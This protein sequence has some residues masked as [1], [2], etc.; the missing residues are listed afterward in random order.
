VLDPLISPAFYVGSEASDSG[1]PDAAFDPATGSYLV[2]WESYWSGSDVDVYGQ[3]ISASGA[4]LGLILPVEPGISPIS[5]NPTVASAPGGSRYLV[6][7][8]QGP[9]PLGP[10]EVWARTVEASSG[11]LGPSGRISEAGKHS[12][13]P[14]AGTLGPG[15]DSAALVWQEQ[16]DGIRWA[17]VTWPSGVPGA[18][19]QAQVR[20]CVDCARPKI[21]RNGAGLRALVVWEELVGTQSDVWAR[22][23]TPSGSMTNL[24]A[25]AATTLDESHPDVDGDG[26]NWLVAYESDPSGSAQTDIHSRK[27]SYT[28]SPTLV[29]GIPKTVEASAGQ[30]EAA[31]A[32]AYAGPK[33]LVAFE[34]VNGLLDRDVVGVGINPKL[35]EVCEPH[36]TLLAGAEYSGEV[37]LAAR[38]SASPSAGDEVLAVWQQALPAF[39]ASGEVLGAFWEAIGPGGSVVNVG[40][41]CAGGGAITT[42]G[43]VSVGNPALA[44]NLTG[45]SGAATLALLNIALAPVPSACGSCTFNLPAILLSTGMAGGAASISIPVP[46]DAALSGAVFQAQ[47][48]V[49]P[50]GLAPCPTFP[51]VSFSDRLS[52]AVGF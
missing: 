28:G 11:A 1:D 8:Q 17:R 18:S 44:I 20:A 24:V 43:A 14:D 30:V 51:G 31:P 32:V 4:A 15:E 22:A 36:H 35:F 6:A 34:D 39:P 42:A 49:L 10:F 3:R 9:G 29:M 48:A 47:W 7:W 33:Y 26:A 16:G 46:C 12:I 40:G 41:G 52:M 19:I 21:A 38:V 45:A 5:M 50:T 27:V 13:D 2:V 23:V 37:A 25:V